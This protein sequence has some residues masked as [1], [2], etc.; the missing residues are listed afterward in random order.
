VCACICVC[1]VVCVCVCVCVCVVLV[2]GI[3]NWTCARK[4]L[5]HS[6]TFQPNFYDFSWRAPYK[7]MSVLTKQGTTTHQKSK[8]NILPESGLADLCTYKW[9]HSQGVAHGGARSMS[10]GSWKPHWKHW[11]IFPDIFSFPPSS[12]PLSFLPSLSF[13]LSSFRLFLPFFLPLSF[14]PPSFFHDAG[15]ENTGPQA[16]WVNA[17]PLRYTIAP[18]STHILA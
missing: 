10:D 2:C 15:D 13:S 14:F 16:C 17:L 9:E 7:Q 8:I 11:A 6:V 12:L 5:Y 4:E 3:G 18:F 1:Y